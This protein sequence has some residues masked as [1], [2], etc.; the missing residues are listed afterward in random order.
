M[1][2]TDVSKRESGPIIDHSM[3]FMI[4]DAICNHFKY[5]W[6]SFSFA[7]DA[8]DNSGNMNMNI[9]V[10][11]HAFAFIDYF[12]KYLTPLMVCLADCTRDTKL[13]RELNTRLL[14]LC[15]HSRCQIRRAA[16]DCLL[17]LFT[18]MKHAWLSCLPQ[19]LHS[20]DELLQDEDCDVVHRTKNL[21]AKIH[22]LTKATHSQLSL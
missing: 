6:Y 22:Q 3:F 2:A 1:A 16:V 4:L 15:S 10:D 18:V 8:N 20:I 12:E 17:A 9:D 7:A 19:T 14:D 13:W 21:I 5:C 11:D